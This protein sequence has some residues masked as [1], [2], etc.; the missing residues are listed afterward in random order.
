MHLTLFDRPLDLQV[1]ALQNLSLHNYLE[2]L[3]FQLLFIFIKF[4]N[5]IGI[6]GE[7]FARHAS[8]NSLLLFPLTQIPFSFSYF[9]WPS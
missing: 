9:S 1:S 5:L 3:R 4:Y 2:N 8:S 7:G 6:A